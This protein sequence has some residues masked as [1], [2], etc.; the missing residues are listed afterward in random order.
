MHFFRGGLV[1]FA[2][3]IFTVWLSP[4][5][6]RGLPSAAGFAAVQMCGLTFVTGL[7]RE[8]AWNGYVGPIIAPVAQFMSV[9]VDRE[10]REVRTRLLGA[11]TAHAIH[12]EGLGCTLVHK[13][14]P[15]APLTRAY[16]PQEEAP[17]DANSA[18]AAF[19]TESLQASLDLVWA[20]NE[21]RGNMPIGSVVLFRGEIVA[22]KYA[23]GV[24]P[25]SRLPGWSVTKTLTAVLA[26]RAAELGIVDLYEEGA[27]AR[28]R[29]T[30]DPRAAVSLDDLHRMQGGLAIG[31]DNGGFDPTTEMLYLQADMAGYAAAQPATYPAGS[32]FDYSSGYTLLAAAR[33][34]EAL[35]GHQALLDFA[36]RE[37]FRPLGMTSALVA[38][39]GSGLIVGS[40][41]MYAS[42]RDWA[43]FGW[44]LANGGRANDGTQ[45][46]SKE[47]L[48]WMAEYTEN[49]GGWSYGAGLYLAYRPG[50]WTEERGLPADTIYSQ[51][52]Q[53]QFLVMIPSEELVVAH[54]G[55][56]NAGGPRAFALMARAL[57]A[58]R[59]DPSAA[60]AS[61]GQ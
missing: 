20:D 18:A 36:D 43:R 22:E 35:G 2:A 29:G 17:L 10:K 53:G 46:L 11:F 16:R 57:A 58:R 38:P 26:A 55:A 39:D 6:Q 19:D 5:G 30:D 40:S 8:R 56:A 7:D 51:G 34:A 54:F 24:S 31:E 9:T 41:Y 60:P 47:S 12:R 3:L 48:A 25:T 1:L 28:Y 13:S 4:L 59:A 50:T 49:S 15:P 52:I 45:I 37:V 14:Q 61:K 23:D 21:R 42:A 27:I 32:D 44:M 33:L